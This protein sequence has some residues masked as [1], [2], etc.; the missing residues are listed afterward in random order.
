MVPPFRDGDSFDILRKDFL[1]C[2]TALHGG[3]R[4]Q[5]RVIQG[6][7]DLADAAAGLILIAF[8]AYDAGCERPTA[9]LRARAD[10]CIKIEFFAG[11]NLC[12]IEKR[13]GL[14]NVSNALF[15]ARG[16][17]A[18]KACLEFGAELRNKFQFFHRAGGGDIFQIRR[19]RGGILPLGHQRK[20][21]F[22]QCLLV[23]HCLLY[24]S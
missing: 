1:Q 18:A 5:Q 17:A 6:S 4:A 2:G 3:S 21:L 23:K 13:G 20:N 11:L 7:A 22:K 10:E 12:T 14:L 9:F 15:V 19:K 16:T 8:T 24:T